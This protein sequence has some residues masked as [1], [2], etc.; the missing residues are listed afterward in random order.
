VN[1]YYYLAMGTAR[2]GLDYATIPPKVEKLF[3]RMV[4]IFDDFVSSSEVDKV[5]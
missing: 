5:K 3:K 1:A 4:T 2:C